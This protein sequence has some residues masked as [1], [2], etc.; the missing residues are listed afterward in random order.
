MSAPA[1]AH[2]RRHLAPHE[3]AY[4]ELCGKN[5]NIVPRGMAQLLRTFKSITEAILF[6]EVAE[7]T[8]CAPT[9]GEKPR[10]ILL[11]ESR[12][13]EISGTSENQ[14]A[15]ALKELTER[16]V[17]LRHRHGR[18]NAYEINFG[19][20][21]RLPKRPKRTLT[22]K[23]LV[24]EPDFEDA[25]ASVVEP[26]ARRAAFTN[27][28]SEPRNVT[29]PAA[30]ANAVVV[31]LPGEK[32]ARPLS[33][34]CPQ[35]ANCELSKQVAGGTFRLPRDGPHPIIPIRGS[36]AAGG[37]FSAK[38][39]DSKSVANPNPQVDLGL[40]V[41][42]IQFQADVLAAVGHRIQA[43][44]PAGMIEGIF[45]R[46]RSESVNPDRFRAR[47]NA[48]RSK[49]HSWRMLD[50][51]LEDVLGFARIESQ[52]TA[53][54]SAA[55]DAQGR[56]TLRKHVARC[57]DEVR[58]ISGLGPILSA[59]H[60]ILRSVDDGKP[61]GEIEAA[62]RTQEDAMIERAKEMLDAEAQ[63]ELD[64]EVAAEMRPHRDR[65]TKEQLARLRDQAI[66]L[67]VMVLF[68]LPRL[69]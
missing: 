61:R 5:F 49:V 46:L 22:P 68:N 42:F 7:R 48:R 60:D 6:F 28:A 36:V 14:A 25:E 30:L 12:A 54:G 44:P 50:P 33:Q 37:E 4:R 3:I 23:P 69:T 29:I 15:A 34:T 62:L 65:F 52:T 16:K 64:A 41:E 59:L 58:P 53:A 35:G 18:T 51:L 67:R 40:S 63:A 55:V 8:C 38:P 26:G 56:A 57:I 24:L 19:L 32:R 39:V 1:M 13:A 2:P 47:L 27:A 11:P 43:P 10:E 17:L 20:W 66:S 31:F 9:A 21:G 45:A